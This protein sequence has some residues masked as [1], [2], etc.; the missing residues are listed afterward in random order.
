[1][2]RWYY[3]MHI[4]DLYEERIW[5]ISWFKRLQTVVLAFRRNAVFIKLD[6]FFYSAI[7]V[8]SSFRWNC[9]AGVGVVDCER[10]NHLARERIIEKYENNMNYF[11][12]SSI[13]WESMRRSDLCGIFKTTPTL[14]GDW[15]KP[16]SINIGRH[17]IC[18]HVS[19]KHANVEADCS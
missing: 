15:M 8:E 19:R 5:W 4:D 10:K 3:L 9:S 16:C 11:G 2:L 18:I 6:A 12:R 13:M 7:A 1:M 14:R 17:F